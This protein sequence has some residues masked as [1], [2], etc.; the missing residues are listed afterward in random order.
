MAKDEKLVKEI[1]PRDVDFAQW[2]TDVVKKAELTAYSRVRGCMILRPYGFAIWENIQRDL[3]RRFKETGHQNVAMPL[4]I[5]ESLLEKEKDHVEGFAPEVAWVTE[6]GNN[7]LQE[8][9]CIRPTSEALFC[10]HYAEIIQSWRDLPKLY[11]QWVSVV[12]WEKTT[13]PF[14]RT[15]E[16]YWQEGHTAHASAEEALEETRRMLQVYIDFYRECLAIPVISG[17]KTD[18]EKFAGAE[19]TY[20]V[21]AMMHDGKALQAGTSHYFG[22]GFA[23]A[24]GIQY[25]DENNEL[26]Y[27]YQTSWGLSTRS[28]GGL[29]MVHSDDDGLVLPPRVAPYQIVL[30]PV[31][32]QKEGVKEANEE[33][34]ARLQ[35]RFRMTSDFSDRMP[36]WK[37]SEYEMRGVPLRLEYGPKDIEKGQVVAVR[38]DK[39]EKYFLP[40]EGLEDK[41][42]EILDQMHED[43]L[44]RA[45]KSLYDRIYQ[46]KN[47]AELSETIKSKA[48]F[49]KAHW[50]GDQA[51]EEK[52]KAELQ[53]TSR[54]IIDEELEE[55]AACA[56]CGREA[57]HLVYWGKAY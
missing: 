46:A 2:Y 24:F 31:A 51:C 19:Q 13:R 7:K 40:L 16:F 26:Q 37:F 57:K 53:A 52:V 25:A 47:W 38:R 3:D 48:G 1:T 33:L 15:S 54:C 32:L 55:G 12:R 44:A 18:K 41:L 45:E 39:R 43:M 56:I 28:I 17:L 22:N 10:D 50:C 35:G 27:V 11:N 20:T 23:Q 34:L 42:Q 4:L 5:P 9:L 30:I 6:G 14:L 29:I 21:E 8:R 36:G 49:V